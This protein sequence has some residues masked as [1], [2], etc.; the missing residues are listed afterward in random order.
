MNS[1]AYTNRFKLPF[2]IIAAFVCFAFFFTCIL[3]PGQS[4]AQDIKYLN[5]PTPGTMVRP[6]N[7]F[8]PVLLK[9]MTIHPEDPFQFDFI[10]D[11]GN[12]NLKEDE[13][14]IESERLVKYFLASMTIPKDDLWVNLSPHEKDRIVPD[15]LGKTELGRD[16]LAQDYILK[17]LTAS[18]I[19]PE[20]ELGAK[21]WDKIHKLAKERFGTTE[22]PVNTFNKVWILPESATV[23]EHEQTV[24]IVGGRL[25]VMLDEDYLSLKAEEEKKSSLRGAHQ[26]AEATR[27][28]PL[29][30]Q[31]IREIVIPEIEKEVNQGKHFAPLRQIYHSLI[32]AK[33]YKETI[34]DS[35]LSKVYVDQN[36]VDGVDMDDDTIKDQ[37]Y[38]QYIEAYK[39]GVFNYIKEDHDRLS[40]EMIPRKYFSGGI[41]G[42]VVIV[43]S[44][45]PIKESDRPKYQASTVIVPQKEGQRSPDLVLDGND[46]FSKLWIKIET[47]EK[48]ESILESMADNVELEQQGGEYLKFVKLKDKNKTII[49]VANNERT[50]HEL[51]DRDTNWNKRK[52]IIQIL[53]SMINLA[54]FTDTETNLLNFKSQV[55]MKVAHHLNKI[56][57]G[58]AVTDQDVLREFF[59]NTQN[60]FNEVVG[61]F[62]RGA[63]SYDTRQYADYGAQHP[64]YSHITH[65]G[66]IYWKEI[67]QL[68]RILNETSGREDI[69]V[70]DMGTGGANFILTAVNFLSKK[71]LSRIQFVGIDRKDSD[72]RFGQEML[73][74]VEDLRV[75]WITADISDPNVF[76]FLKGDKPDLIVCN[77]VLEYLKGDP[78]EYISRWAK[79]SQNTIMVSIPL[80]DFTSEH[81]NFFDVRKN[82]K[83]AVQVEEKLEGEVKVAELEKTIDGGLWVFRK[84]GEEKKE[85]VLSSSRQRHNLSIADDFGTKYDA[86][87]DGGVEYLSSKQGT[88]SREIVFVGQGLHYGSE[89]T[90]TI[91]PA[92]EDTGIIFVRDGGQPKAIPADI[93]YIVET[94]KATKI[95]NGENGHVLAPEHILSALGSVGI[96][97]AYIHLS[98]GDEVPI[99]DG[100]A[101]EF[102]A[103]LL[104]EGVVKEL[105][106]EREVF[107]VKRPIIYSREGEGVK[108]LILPA[109]KRQLRMSYF[110][111]FDNPA[112]GAQYKTI[113]LDKEN[114]WSEVSDSRTFIEEKYLEEL[115]KISRY[116]GI[117]GGMAAVL[118]D[119][120]GR[121]IGKGFS[122]RDEAI[123]HKILD[124]FG[125]LQLAG[126]SLY[127]HVI[128][129]EA[130]HRDHNELV[131]KIV[132]T[133]TSGDY[134][135]Y[136]EEQ[137]L[138]VVNKF[139]L[140]RDSGKIPEELFEEILGAF[141]NAGWVKQKHNSSSPSIGKEARSMI[142]TQ[143]DP[144][145]HHLIKDEHVKLVIELNGKFTAKYNERR[146]ESDTERYQRL[147]D[148]IVWDKNENAYTGGHYPGTLSWDER[149][150]PIM[151]PEG[152]EIIPQSS[153]PIDVFDLTDAAVKAAF[154]KENNEVVLSIEGSKEVIKSAY[155]RREVLPIHYA[156]FPDGK[157]EH[158]YLLARQFFI[159]KNRQ[160]FRHPTFSNVHLLAA[161]FYHLENEY[162]GTLPIDPEKRL[163]ELFK[164]NDIK[165]VLE[166]GTAGAN[167]F[168]VIL[169]SIIEQVDGSVSIIDFSSAE[170]ADAKRV[171]IHVVQGDA[172]K[173]EEYFEGKKFDLILNSGVLSHGGV[174]EM[175]HGRNKKFPWMPEIEHSKNTL[176]FFKDAMDLLQGLL[177]SISNNPKAVIIANGLHSHLSLFRW[178]VS[179]VAAVHIWDN[180][181]E[182]HNHFD[183]DLDISYESDSILNG[184]RKTGASLMIAGKQSSDIE[185]D[186]SIEFDFGEKVLTAKYLYNVGHGRDFVAREARSILKELYP[187]PE[188][189]IKAYTKVLNSDDNYAASSMAAVFLGQLGVRSVI[190]ILKEIAK[191]YGGRIGRF[192][193]HTLQKLNESSSPINEHADI[194]G[195]D[196]NEINVDRQGTRIDVQF[197]P[198]SLQPIMDMQIDGFAPVIINII[199]LPSIMPLLGLDDAEEPLELSS[200]K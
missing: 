81:E 65:F 124:L 150:E 149:I 148:S 68:Q 49:Y 120:K 1:L 128:A 85:R 130:G 135:E 137:V 178:D 115:G 97:N 92:K 58:P 60:R 139:Q 98:G 185:S 141:I 187:T 154:A 199:P 191:N 168:M 195:I 80:N 151:F 47:V 20:D 79:V 158:Y 76:D 3:P 57:L 196:L 69:L 50:F 133:S 197:A 169:N 163:V 29:A 161:L 36:K 17:Q 113:T 23:Y 11:S 155:E 70:V 200:T 45:S 62:N 126:F 71:D 192:A 72:R 136:D 25:K 37:I 40:N 194:G 89:I 30:S 198:E 153:S 100:S 7:A 48:I 106:A 39:K 44:S 87:D 123:R 4:Y 10:V 94:S 75:Q 93:N 127:G 38:D 32:L 67:S 121:F 177:D 117:K 59:V 162:Q 170:N 144:M 96:N 104:E 131:R 143:L 111:E 186:S 22:I 132:E 91:R 138:E 125:D 165:H 90:M 157:E 41:K 175:G 78:A 145:Q 31:I 6:S 190:P 13:L 159:L 24:Y 19:Y 160:G 108:V 26:P 122:R 55:A 147:L 64:V 174:A 176:L 182:R 18:L 77:H 156:Q 27:Q 179:K 14:K 33:W 35:L 95:V 172:R 5:L 103:K 164:K 42:D 180:A 84:V 9:G 171:G 15:E 181:F 63:S 112:I 88:V 46:G 74:S 188:E 152:I 99:F 82:K 129:V 193:E 34:K 184:L 83:I 16:M 134:E 86:F 53:F 28:S 167:A 173:T 110:I 109:M 102:K 116:L 146:E 73:E 166:V 43:R 140:L 119:E 52:E 8:V 114:Y 21:F 61:S 51:I 101:A 142:E 2:R 54:D 12:T 105:E 56:T 189:K 183:K 118:L 107:S 66:W